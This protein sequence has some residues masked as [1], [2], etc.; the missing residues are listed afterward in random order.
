MEQRGP[1]GAVPLRGPVEVGPLSG[2][3][4]GPNL[5]SPAKPI[6]AIGLPWRLQLLP[7]ARAAADRARSA[8]GSGPRAPRRA[9]GRFTAPGECPG[10]P[11]GYYPFILGR[12]AS[13]RQRLPRAAGRWDLGCSLWCFDYSYASVLAREKASAHLLVIRQVIGETRTSGQGKK[14]KNNRKKQNKQT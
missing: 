9:G 4:A 14:K 1:R 3:R 13:R 11:P 6:A 2:R 7:A 5:R 10:C 12:V 8:V